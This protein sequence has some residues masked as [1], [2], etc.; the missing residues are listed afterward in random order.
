MHQ[1][2]VFLSSTFLDFQ[3]ERDHL[4]TCVLPEVNAALCERGLRID[5]IDLRWGVSDEAGL[6][7]AAVEV[8]LGEIERCCAGDAAPAFILMLGEREGWQ[9]LPTLIEAGRFAQLLEALPAG[10]PGGQVLRAWY[11]R[12]DNHL[13][14]SWALRSR[15]GTPEA[16]PA[17][18]S[19]IEHGLIEAVVAQAGTL[20]PELVALFTTPVTRMEADRALALVGRHPGRVSAMRRYGGAGAR[21]GLL[22]RLFGSRAR[23]A[24]DPGRPRL[25]AYWDTLSQQLGDA[26]M[27][28]V[29]RDG[30]DENYR[31]CFDAWARDCL[32]RAVPSGAGADPSP[33]VSVVASAPT[34]PR[35]IERRL[36]DWLAAPGPGVVLVHGR[37]GSGK[38]VLARRFRQLASERT[39]ARGVHLAEDSVAYDTAG[40]L[41]RLGA[42]LSLPV[43]AQEEAGARIARLHAALGAAGQGVLVV[44]ALESVAWRDASEA[45]AWLPDQVGA[46][47]RVLL[48][49]SSDAI[50]QAFLGLYPEQ[51]LAVLDEM[52]DEESA[53][54][55]EAVLAAARRRVTPAQATALVE[56]TRGLPGRAL[57][58][59]IAA[60]FARRL[61]ADAPAP[62]RPEGLQGWV[63]LWMEDLA[64]ARGH[65]RPLVASTLALVFVARHRVSELDLFATLAHSGEVR[66]WFVA[67]FPFAP[68][69]PEGLPRTT[70]SRLMTDLSDMFDEDGGAGELYY[71]LSHALLRDALAAELGAERLAWAHRELAA[72]GMEDTAT[73]VAGDAPSPYRLGET[74]YQLVRSGPGARATLESLYAD[75]G[76]LAAKTAP[77]GLA[78]TLEEVDLLHAD[79]G[80]DSPLLQAAG[81]LLRQ[82]GAQLRRLPEHAER[83]DL[84]RQAIDVDLAS[85][86]LRQALHARDDGPRIRQC[87]VMPRLP[88]LVRIDA[89]PSRALVRSLAFD[90]E[91]AM[92]QEDGSIAIVG[93]LHGEV[94][95]QLPGHPGGDAA[96]SGIELVPVPGRRL[97][98]CGRDGEVALSSVP[99]GRDLLRLATG[100]GPVV[101]VDRLTDGT[102]M[103]FGRGR[104]DQGGILYRWSADGTPSGRIEVAGSSLPG[105]AIAAD[106]AHVDTTVA[107]D[108]AL[109]R[110]N[111]AG[112]RLFA[113]FQSHFAAIDHDHVLTTG[114]G[115]TAIWSFRSGG[116]VLSLSSLFHGHSHAPKLVLPS[117]GNALLATG[118][119]GLLRLDPHEGRIEV[120]QRGTESGGAD[121]LDDARLFSWTTDPDG[122][123]CITLLD[124]AS[125]EVLARFR[126][127]P[128]EEP[129]SSYFRG[130]ASNVFRGVL[131][132]DGHLLAWS[133]YGCERVD[134]DEGRLRSLA[135]WGF[136]QY[137]TQALAIDGRRALLLQGGRPVVFDSVLGAAIYDLSGRTGQIEELEALGDG[138]MLAKPWRGRPFY[139]DVQASLRWI[140]SRDLS[141]LGGQPQGTR[142]AL[143]LP[144]RHLL[145]RHRPRPSAVTRFG[146]WQAGE[147]QLEQAAEIVGVEIVDEK[148]EGGSCAN[149]F[150]PLLLLHGGGPGA[151]RLVALPDQG[152]FEFRGRT[153]APLRHVLPLFDEDGSSRLAVACVLVSDGDG[154]EVVAI[155]NGLSWALPR[156]DAQPVLGF[157]RLDE[158]V[159]LVATA[160]ALWRIDFATLLPREPRYIRLAG[161]D[162]DDG[163]DAEVLGLVHGEADPAGLLLARCRQVPGDKDSP[164]ETLVLAYD[165]ARGTLDRQV[166]PHASQW[167]VVDGGLVLHPVSGAAIDLRFDPATRTM[168]PQ[169]HRVGQVHAWPRRPLQRIVRSLFE[170]SG[171]ERR[172]LFESHP[173]LVLEWQD[174]AG[175]LR[176]LGDR[177]ESDTSRGVVR[178]FADGGYD[179]LD[180][181]PGERRIV[182]RTR[183]DQ[184][185]QLLDASPDPVAPDPRQASV[186]ERAKA[187]VD[188]AL[189]RLLRRCGQ[190]ALAA[191]MARHWIGE[192]E[193]GAS[194]GKAERLALVLLEL[195]EAAIATGD[196]ELTSRALQEQVGLLPAIR[197]ESGA[198]AVG[199]LSVAMAETAAKHAIISGRPEDAHAS[200]LPPLG[201][202]LDPAL[203]RYRLA[204]YLHAALPLLRPDPVRHARVLAAREALGEALDA[205]GDEA[206][207]A[208]A[209]VLGDLDWL[210]ARCA[211]PPTPDPAGVDWAVAA[212]D[213]HAAS[214]QRALAGDGDACNTLGAAFGRGQSVERNPAFAA[215][216]YQRGVH[217]GH[218]PSAF[219]LS[220]M[221]RHGEGVAKDLVRS[222]ELLRRAAEG[223]ITMAKSNLGNQLIRG[224]GCAPDPVEARLWLQQA[225]AEGDTLAPV[226]LALLLAT[227]EGGPRDLAGARELL[228]PLARLGNPNAITLLARLEGAAP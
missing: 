65:G 185:I 183:H 52:D 35:R 81:E 190:P 188:P 154:L 130:A 32:L 170:G 56:G 28:L 16:D 163:E 73:G 114:M 97:L 102:L 158:G 145:A 193:Q 83:A 108:L 82:L 164:F 30:S 88:G 12:D 10:T 111:S 5:L 79:R 45:L 222:F 37:S 139:W 148:G 90:D 103:A 61:A 72:R 143:L 214:L 36:L 53:A 18:W 200:L 128:P 187:Q 15:R 41:E 77:A 68:P 46:G 199:W 71:R 75:V 172:P 57:A 226:S 33:E 152:V 34:V 47:T 210:L 144:G 17:R 126:T 58:N 96:G 67:A 38:S 176:F 175:R 40:F 116:A 228:Q 105:Q 19:A 25:D 64:E 194:A 95:R 124:I 115:A 220:Q 138:R 177:I 224:E 22:R 84:L 204:V 191:A 162:D 227:G 132:M 146:L 180:F 131:P 155:E 120:L 223:G 91:L 31:A 74:L 156:P 9:P 54:Q 76:V 7:H 196:I 119:G 101:R 104:D 195:A 60:V 78:D 208:G 20:A 142:D 219:N 69:P 100:G 4:N 89:D 169:P 121:Q 147:R 149:R 92:V 86:P 173:G 14:P 168:A 203:L 2:R 178:W 123:L 157:V 21:A 13:P 107:T 207:A 51:A 125:G 27:E 94:R 134:L 225:C 127:D 150:G 216:W 26:A 184:T 3:W 11:R 201:Q 182:V 117:R 174:D 93:A 43:V 167:T 80:W 98:S 151:F 166:L 6:D 55:I 112:N 133:G 129:S 186:V 99:A 29:S 62:A 141:E 181:D 197:A 59:R 189:A 113:A 87:L 159:V 110:L 135:R 1:V 140:D 192:V 48:T 49:T 212:G 50:R 211:P 24:D 171:V 70:F 23:P 160:R 44:D 63:R 217:A 218:S 109:P 106:G 165:L 42:C 215:Y 206:A 153:A 221:Y 137:T 202:P 85:N 66:A 118:G 209:G 122:R 205:L 161:V 179:V 8:C 198:H 39:R 213:A 136:D